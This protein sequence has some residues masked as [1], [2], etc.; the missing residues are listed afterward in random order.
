M[1][2]HWPQYVMAV[3]VAVEL[4]WQMGRDGQ[5]HANYSFAPQ[6]V[7]WCFIVAMLFFGGFWT[8]S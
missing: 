2:W 5:P 6:F 7:C 3:F 8:P 1:N 4:G